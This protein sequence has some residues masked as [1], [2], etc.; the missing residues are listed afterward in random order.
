MS[1]DIVAVQM[2]TRYITFSR[3]QSGFFFRAD[4]TVISAVLHIFE[5]RTLSV[6]SS[7]GNGWSI[8]SPVLFRRRL[9]FGIA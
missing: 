6:I 5:F 2:S 4:K 3:A 9:V 7:T 8:P 1:N